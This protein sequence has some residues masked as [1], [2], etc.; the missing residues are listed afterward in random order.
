M[1]TQKSCARTM[2]AAPICMV[3]LAFPTKSLGEQVGGTT[4]DCSS[5]PAENANHCA[6]ID[7]VRENNQTSNVGFITSPLV[8]GSPYFT[9]EHILEQINSDKLLCNTLANIP[10][11]LFKPDRNEDNYW[12]ISA[13]LTAVTQEC[14][15][16]SEE[17]I[18]EERKEEL[19]LWARVRLSEVEDDLEILSRTNGY[20]FDKIRVVGNQDGSITEL[21]LYEP[22]VE[23]DEYSHIPLTYSPDKDG[24]VRELSFYYSFVFDVGFV[25]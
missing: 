8:S 10:N 18:S 23:K 2:V 17:V 15:A 19:A 12:E 4:I 5:A 7:L 25:Q 11:I 9:G 14:R 22:Y 3:F 20:T 13:S 24:I 21:R 1:K 6:F 16:S